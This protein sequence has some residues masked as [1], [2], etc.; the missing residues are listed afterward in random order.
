MIEKMSNFV[1]PSFITE[2]NSELASIL[3]EYSFVQDPTL[4]IPERFNKR[5]TTLKTCED[6]VHLFHTIFFWGMKEIPTI[7]IDA[8]IK[9]SGSLEV[10]EKHDLLDF[11]R[12]TFPASEVLEE[13][14][15]I[16]DYGQSIFY[17]KSD[18]P[19]KG[20]VNIT[21][22]FVEK[23]H[24]PDDE[25]DIFTYASRYD[26][27]ILQYLDSIGFHPSTKSLIYEY[28]VSEDI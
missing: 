7:I 16:L 5:D 14:L 28:H 3:K 1:F 22:F 25:K 23:D 9:C 8:L 21:R 11:L 13:L 24:I 27:S 4:I 18:F 20:Y 2:K 26:L 6:V 19:Y 10:D 12:D 15:L 17:E